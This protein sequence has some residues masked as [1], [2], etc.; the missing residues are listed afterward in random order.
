MYVTTNSLNIF[1][2]SKR[3]SRFEAE[4]NM[5][6]IRKIRIGCGSDISGMHFGPLAE[7]RDRAVAQDLQE[8]IGV[9]IHP[10]KPYAG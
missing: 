2:A 5:P 3:G 4:S 9:P 7:W 10:W 8:A 6:S 1:N